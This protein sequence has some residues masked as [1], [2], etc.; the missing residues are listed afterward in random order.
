MIRTVTFFQRPEHLVL[1]PPG[2][3][4]EFPKGA[5]LLGVLDADSLTGSVL[6]RAGV[7]SG[8]YSLFS[9]CFLPNTE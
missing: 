5:S 3:L 2:A 4:G 6:I 1:R 8:S 7:I 9:T